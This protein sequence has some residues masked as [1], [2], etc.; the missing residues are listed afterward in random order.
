VRYNHEQRFKKLKILWLLFDFPQGIEQCQHQFRNER[1]N[2]T[3]KDDQN[4]FGATLERGESRNY[5][6]FHC[7]CL[8]KRQ[9]GSRNPHTGDNVRP[10]AKEEK[11]KY[12]LLF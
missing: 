6:I 9:T 8:Y 7:V 11:G 5:F 2:C 10:F 4:V 12:L 1:W 3:T